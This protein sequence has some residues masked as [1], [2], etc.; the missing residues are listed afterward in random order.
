V[1]AHKGV[2]QNITKGEPKKFKGGRRVVRKKEEKE[3][4]KSK[5]LQK[6]TLSLLTF[7]NHSLLQIEQH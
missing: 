3:I 7:F 5:F 4:K 1:K 6:N 2:T